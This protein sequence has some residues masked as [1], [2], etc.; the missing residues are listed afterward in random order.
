M[1]YDGLSGLSVYVHGAW[2][3]KA[4]DGQEGFG[5]RARLKV[6]AG[7]LGTL[8]VHQVVRDICRGE[9]NERGLVFTPKKSCHQKS[10]I[11]TL[12]ICLWQTLYYIVDK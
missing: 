1:S 5:L 11:S 9:G 2:V 8:Y 6:K 12:F 10:E 7:Q 3:A 4:G